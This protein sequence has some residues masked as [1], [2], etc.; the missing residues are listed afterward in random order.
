M[1]AGRVGGAVSPAR[2]ELERL[3]QLDL[4]R[5]P[6]LQQ[7]HLHPPAGVSKHR[8]QVCSSAHLLPGVEVEVTRPVGALQRPLERDEAGQLPEVSPALA[9]LLQAGGQPGLLPRPVPLQ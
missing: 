8:L 2:V 1:L 3:G 5:L 6:P 7:G 9:Q 4:A